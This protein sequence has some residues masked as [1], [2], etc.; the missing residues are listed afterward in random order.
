MHP[1]MQ[2]SAVLCSVPYT[3]DRFLQDPL[4]AGKSVC[5][6]LVVPNTLRILQ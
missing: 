2:V 4:L 5:S 6:T 3:L 1:V